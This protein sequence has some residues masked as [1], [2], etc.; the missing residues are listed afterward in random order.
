MSF[1][2]C[3]ACRAIY[4]S[5]FLRC[6]SDGGA[7][8][9]VENDPLVGE[10][11]AEHYRVEE[12]LGEGAMGRVYRAHHTRLEH[13]RYAL[14]VLIGDFS[15]TVAMR[16][17]FAQEAEMASRLE[18]PNVV[19][20]VDFGKTDAGLLYLAMELVEG[21]TLAKLIEREAP[22][23]PARVLR[24]AKQLC[25]GLR[26]AHERHVVHRDFK[27]DNVLVVQ[28]DGDDLPR[29]GDF[30][31][32][33]SADPDTSTRLTSVGLV[34]CTPIY[35]APE[36]ITGG[37]VDT[38]A[39]L[40]ALGV[41][42]YEMLTG[43]VP[44]DGGVAEVLHHKTSS[45]PPPMSSRAPGVTVPPALDRV[46]R[47]LMAR[48][49]AERYQTAAEVLA[50]LDAVD[51]SAPE[52]EPVPVPAP[53]ESS[54]VVAEVVTPPAPRR[55]RAPLL[56]GI[57]ALAALGVAV[58][59]FARSRDEPAP[60]AV[61]SVVAGSVAPD[62]AEAPRAVP[63]AAAVIA[64]PPA[65]QPEAQIETA[66]ETPPSSSK[67]R[68]P[69]RARAEPPRKVEAAPAVVVPEPETPP[70]AQEPKPAP[71]T[72]P[73][74]AEDPP[75]E[76]SAPKPVEKPK[77]KPAVPSAVKVSIQGL[78]VHGSLTSA[79]VERAL[80]R[81]IPALQRCYL[82][83]ARAAG[84]GPRARLSVHLTIDEQRRARDVGVG[85]A[86]LAKLSSCA[87]GALGAVRTRIAPDVGDVDV[88]FELV[89]VP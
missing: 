7:I 81:V 37:A 18:H 31:L 54:V 16:L 82:D 73:P 34:L 64:E 57:A 52:P 8:E 71:E 76:P 14:K 70:P 17:R 58:A 80:G 20:V 28:R 55:S 67:A 9:Q 45:D 79:V 40:F 12:L 36:Q 23:E 51:L 56:G 62:A 19:P 77:P 3:T 5:D 42:L 72:A 32:A 25:Q 66:P 50:A 68:R 63:D 24:L 78:A 1:R 87:Q 53:V 48:T 60:P 38:R 29:I 74:A 69:N 84:K 89:F 83:A 33:I 44:F 6:P 35:A 10:T 43:K 47:R 65:P 61:A 30:G 86:P 59:A 75:P 27:P 21:P 85:K 11:V 46:V 26:H 88:A 22:L 4:R 13:R 41:T 39:D 49:P 15:T 2:C